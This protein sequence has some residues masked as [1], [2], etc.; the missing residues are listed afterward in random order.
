[1]HYVLRC[2]F[3]NG[4]SVDYVKGHICAN[5]FLAEVNMKNLTQ[6]KLDKYRN[7]QRNYQNIQWKAGIR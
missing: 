7:D 4:G 1:M 5:R 3:C 2:S 6:L